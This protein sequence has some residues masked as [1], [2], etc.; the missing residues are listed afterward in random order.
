MMEGTIG[1][2][3]GHLHRSETT[4]DGGIAMLAATGLSVVLKTAETGRSSTMIS[5]TSSAV[6]TLVSIIQ[7]INGAPSAGAPA[8]AHA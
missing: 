4:G 3:V 1:Y 6:S 5:S 8:G 7:S 2:L